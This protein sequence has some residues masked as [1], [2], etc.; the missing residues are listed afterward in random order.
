MSQVSQD[1]DLQDLKKAWETVDRY[2]SSRRP[3][4][5]SRVRRDLQET[6]S[7]SISEKLD[8]IVL[9]LK[10][11][12]PFHGNDYE[13]FLDEKFDLGVQVINQEFEDVWKNTLNKREQ[14]WSDY[15]KL[16]EAQKF[17]KAEDCYTWKKNS[18][19]MNLHRKILS[20][21][22]K[23]TEKRLYAS[24]DKVQEMEKTIQDMESREK[25]L[26][27]KIIQLGEIIDER[28]EENH[29]LVLKL[30]RYTKTNAGYDITMHK[31][32]CCNKPAID[33]Q[34]LYI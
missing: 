1:D 2:G 3:A 26:Q 25:D 29:E 12:G 9:D 33:L 22:L 16:L 14:E 5:F 6:F 31:K 24:E 28:M 34:Q 27:N 23:D 32:F 13:K 21:K 11:N 17:L 7:I 15:V 19:D 30:K 18:D 20:E 8:A 4:K 10:M